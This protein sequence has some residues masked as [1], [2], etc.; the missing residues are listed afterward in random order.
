[1][2]LQENMLPMGDGTKL[3]TRCI[4]PHSE[5]SFPVVFAR[6]CYAPFEAAP[7]D[8]LPREITAEELPEAERNDLLVLLS[9]GYAIIN[10]HSRGT[11]RSEGEFIPLRDDRR[12]GEDT[13][14]W[15]RAQPFYQREMYVFGGS[16]CALNLLAFLDLMGDDLKGV[17]LR[18]PYSGRYT[19]YYMNG[20]LRADLQLGWYL[21]NYCK[22]QAE[23]QP[24]LA[25][26]LG[27]LRRLSIK[28]YMSE[29]FPKG[30][31]LFSPLLS[32]T[33]PNEPLW[34]DERL[35]FPGSFA[36]KHCKAPI[37]LI[38]GWFDIFISGMI[39]MW[40]QLPDATRAR[41][42]MVIGPFTHECTVNPPDTT[43]PLPNSGV[44]REFDTVHVWL[45][46]LRQNAPLKDITPGSVRYYNIGASVWQT[47]KDVPEGQTQTMFHLANDGRLSSDEQYMQPVRYTY[48]PNT[49]SGIA[50]G[51]NGFCTVPTGLVQQPDPMLRT[52]GVTFIS[53]PLTTAMPLCGS[54][55]ITMTVTSD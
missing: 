20:F 53:E 36:G 24:D 16:Y 33:D 51:N 23:S 18:V 14:A 55:Q 9:E 54:A 37:L 25:A 40:R 11:G 2:I 35:A 3:Y 28:A 45:R 8:T 39:D 19:D 42:A 34:T 44:P 13:L 5:G 17:A 15:L 48:D 22:K 38:G 41:S 30:Q 47:A 50:G 6:T 32:A 27:K 4:M 49:P 31:G 26:E 1:M 29:H 21:H 10:Q 43:L 7:E 52:D 12:D 46:H